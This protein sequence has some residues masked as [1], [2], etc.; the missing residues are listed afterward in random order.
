MAKRW[1]AAERYAAPAVLW[2]VTASGGMRMSLLSVLPRKAAH[3]ARPAVSLITTGAV[4][5]FLMGGP[6]DTASAQTAAGSGTPFKGTAAVGALFV[7]TDGHLGR[8]FCTA[9][10]VPSPSEDL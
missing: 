6:S 4:S 5:A 10:V 8:H 7:Q 3:H 9:S 1:T 2:R